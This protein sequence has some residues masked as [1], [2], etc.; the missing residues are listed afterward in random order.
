M[1]LSIFSYTQAEYIQEIQQLLG[2]GAQHAAKIYS[3]WFKK[4]K[5]DPDAEWIEP[6]AKELVKKIIGATDF[7]LPEISEVKEEGSICKFLL[8]YIDGLESE[9]VVIPMKFGYTLC[10]SSQVG[11]KMGC[12]FCE[13]GKMGLIRHL[14]AH[15]IC[16]QVFAAKFLFNVPIRNLVF[17]GMG[18]PLDNYDEVMRAIQV[19][20]CEAGFGISMSRITVSTSGKIPEMYRF[21]KEADPALRLAISLNAPNDEVRSKLM[22]VNNSW[23]LSELREFM[24]LYGEHP[25]RSILIEYVL[26]EGVND[27][28]AH[29][30]EVAN[31]LEG[32][33]VKVNLIPYNNQSKGRLKPPTEE[34][35]NRFRAVL[36]ASGFQVLLRT[37]KGKSIM[38][39][40]G[41]LGNRNL[42]KMEKKLGAKSPLSVL[43]EMSTV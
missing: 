15:E 41:Q 29:A 5:A 38:A 39:A 12:A 11:C 33:H 17:M 34:S 40:C 3:D 19:L 1:T 8:K 28:E 7:S 31:Y 23:D 4:G 36:Q 14:Q 43:C 25:K 13:T 6:Q 30:L 35:M 42:R 20:S 18:E 9:S 32:L 16:A 24:R 2:K 27:S 26:I 37:S 22:P 10:V 21:L